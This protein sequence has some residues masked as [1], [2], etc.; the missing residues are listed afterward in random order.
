LL[1]RAKLAELWTGHPSVDEVIAIQPGESVWSV[2]GKLRAGRFDT[3]LVLPN[4]PRSAIEVWLSG[5]PR[6]I[7]YARPWRN[8][9]LT[10]AMA[11]RPGYVRMRKK[12]KREIRGLITQASLPPG[13]CQALPVQAHQM[14]EYLHLANTLGANPAPLPPLLRVADAEVEAVRNRFNLSPCVPLLGLNAGAEYGP[15]K[16]WPVNRFISVAIACHE[17]TQCAW[18]ILGGASDIPLANTLSAALQQAGV[19]AHSLAGQTSLRELM[20]ALRCCRVLLTNDTGPMHVG[21]ALG[22]PVVVP[23]GS[24]TPELT[25]PGLPGD[26]GHF[27]LRSNAPCAPC[28]LRSCPIDFRCMEGISIERVRESVLAALDPT[29]R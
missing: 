25:G 28:F 1:T 14:H 29:A 7:G 3:A 26:P 10:Q 15:A 6:R 20:A 19:D 12:A 24:T 18:V 16:R 8:A 22:V 17:R 9:F 4:S 13:R 11:T 27:L 5:I 2:G 23:F 21:A